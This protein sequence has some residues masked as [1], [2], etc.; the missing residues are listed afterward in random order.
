MKISHNGLGMSMSQEQ[1][2]MRQK[3]EKYIWGICE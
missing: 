3:R 1:E 2:K